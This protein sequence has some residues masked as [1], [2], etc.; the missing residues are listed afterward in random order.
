M[1]ILLVEDD[2]M[3]AEI[4]PPVTV[5]EADSDASELI[6]VRISLILEAPP[7]AVWRIEVACDALVAA[8][9]SVETSAEIRVEMARPAASSE[10]CVMR[11]PLDSLDNALVSCAE[12]MFK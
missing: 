7:S 12:L 4:L 6:R 3:L 10:A 8:C 9:C 1:R 2:N 11:L 5:P